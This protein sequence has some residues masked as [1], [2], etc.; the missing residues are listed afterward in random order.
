MKQI[1]LN[2]YTEEINQE[3]E[4]VG[5]EQCKDAA[6]RARDFL[7]R[8]A[9]VPVSERA[10]LLMRLSEHLLAKRRFLAETIT[11][12]M[13]KPIRQA[14]AEIDKC[15]LLCDYYAR[16]SGPF[17]EN[18]IIE[19][20]VY[21]S[22]ITYEPLGVILG[23]M[24][25]NYPF[26]QVL[27]F[28]VPTLMAGN[29]CLLK[30]ASNVPLAAVEV[31]R[32]FQ[33]A[34]FPEP[35]FQTLLTDSETVCRLIETDAVDGVSLT[36]SVQAG[37][38]I[39][40][41][42][43]MNIKKVVLELG[44]SDPFIVLADADLPN[45]ATRA[46]MARTANTGQSCISAKRIIVMEAVADEFLERFTAVLRSLKIGDPMAD[47]NDLG[48]L[49]K[50]EAVIEL[51]AQLDDACTKGAR[52]FWGP[53]P[54]AGKGFFF[55]P[56][57]LTNVTPDMRVM[58]EEVFGPLAPIVIVAN[59]EEAVKTANATEFGLGASIWTQNLEHAEEL[60]REIKTGFVAVNGIVKSDPRLPFGGVKKSGIGREL[61][62]FGLRE[63]TNV[64]T[65]VIHKPDPINSA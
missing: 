13:G 4:S 14:Q 53:E 23:V 24:P 39:G 12:E 60:A 25:W 43:G 2:P 20:G 63:F 1:S 26:W 54:P 52:V 10:G 30:H 41:L 22:Y 58:R 49:A 46:V 36:G 17:L 59:E 5:F 15:R 3:F 31:E 37:A 34:G 62:Y 50:K 9:N 61:A 32:L 35:V 65:M 48:P 56:A 16:C 8:W 64:K 33:E 45:A 7:P 51:T 27:R 29:V 19:T 18:E 21:R 28:A 47:V 6:N 38:R 40:S 57:V 44:G 11:R 55:H 42:A